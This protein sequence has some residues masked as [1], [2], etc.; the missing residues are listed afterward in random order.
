MTDLRRASRSG[1]FASSSSDEIPQVRSVEEV[2]G[3]TGRLPG[4]NICVPISDHQGAGCIGRVRHEGREACAVQ[5]CARTRTRQTRLLGGRDDRAV[6][7]I[8]DLGAFLPEKIDHP[9][10][11][12]LDV[13]NG[14]E[15]SSDAGLVGDDKNPVASRI[16]HLNGL[17]RSRHPDNLV[18]AMGKAG[19]DVHN[20]VAIKKSSGFNRVA[21]ATTCETVTRRLV[22]P[23]FG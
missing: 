23:D 7:P 22:P 6:P 12:R 5:V 13:L 14:V 15:P 11:Q 8:I 21:A 18:R 1:D 17:N 4:F 20:A 3:H 2:T 9:R 16:Q 10:H 19:V